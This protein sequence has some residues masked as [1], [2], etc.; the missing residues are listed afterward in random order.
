MAY[1]QTP[2]VDTRSQH[3]IPVAYS[4]HSED[5]H[6]TLDFPAPDTFGLNNFV[7][8]KRML[9]PDEGELY[10]V[11][12]PALSGAV[13]DNGNTNSLVARGI[14]IWEKT[15][16][17]TYYYAVVGTKVYTSTDGSTWTLRHTLS[18]SATTPVR[19]TEFIN[20]A[21]NAKSLVMLDGVQGFIFTSDAAGTEI[22][23]VDFPTPHIPFPVYLD[24]YLFVAKKDTGDIYNS[25]LNDASAWTAGNFISCELFPDDVKAI[26]KQQNQILAIG[27]HG[28]EY[29]YDA[30]NATGSPLKRI[31]G[32]IL[33]FGTF[34]ADTIAFNK[35]SLTFMANMN[36][37]EPALI[38]V[39]GQQWE[40]ITP[41]FMMPRFVAALD[42]GGISTYDNVW[43]YYTRARGELFY[44]LNINAN[45]TSSEE[46]SGN[47]FVYSFKHKMWMFYTISTDS[48]FTQVNFPV[49]C[50][51]FSGKTPLTYVLGFLN[52]KPFFAKWSEGAD[53]TLQYGVDT[54]TNL[55]YNTG[56]AAG[57]MGMKCV[58]VT[59]GLTFGTYNLKSMSRLGIQGRQIP[60]G[61]PFE[62]EIQFYDGK[63][64]ST[65]KTIDLD[66]SSTNIPHPFLSQCGDFR[67]RQVIMSVYPEGGGVVLYGLFAD[68]NKHML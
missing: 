56:G 58:M 1:T 43:G 60:N 59:P 54:I 62:V 31:D 22:T 51:T 64:V 52:D 46:S 8:Q 24:G 47:T 40:E 45:A 27:L 53:G 44:C 10:I 26:V 21:T 37:G 16:A 36:D 23:D 55:S 48:N 17:L 11:N 4:L 66:F 12:R 14:Y 15:T 35:D 5:Y 20:S 67:E 29:F 57:S 2:R 32:A 25:N 39:K 13:I 65:A 34:F 50:A 3:F 42:G 19:F 49:T 68:I 28:S 38:H 18:T 33:P 7:P 30:A 6:A 61:S 41:N 63:T 9:G